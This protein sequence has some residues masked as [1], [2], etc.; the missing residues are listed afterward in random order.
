MPSL[1]KSILN[2][3]A[4]VLTSTPPSLD[5]DHGRRRQAVVASLLSDLFLG[6]LES[7][8]HLITREL[9]ERFGVS[10][11][12]IR[13]A[14]IELAGIG[15]LELVP[16]RGAVVKT[17]TPRLVRDMFQVRR[18]LECEAVRSACGKID[19]NEL[20]A[21]K[22]E[23]KAIIENWSPGDVRQVDLSRRLDSRLHDLIAESGG[24]SF[25]FNEISRLKILF[26]TF[27][28]FCWEQDL[29]LN[30]LRRI[31]DESQEHLAIVEALIAGDK[32][33]AIR[34]MSVHINGG[35]VY[36]NLAIRDAIQ[37]FSRSD[38]VESPRRKEPRK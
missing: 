16:N 35:A 3:S 27:R 8:K 18:S 29:H 32:K 30:D 38:A 21:L 2:E 23:F 24:N 13:E 14:L 12:P 37:H 19:R 11:T 34:S 33:V 31:V 7:G 5:C 36:W 1:S 17:F 26:R 22:V 28:D 4:R 15:V 9:A 10:H 25:L 6:R 20:E